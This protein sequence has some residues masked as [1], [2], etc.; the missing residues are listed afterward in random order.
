MK[1]MIIYTSIHH[2]NTEKIAREIAKI[3]NAELVKT[4]EVKIEDID[5]YDLIGF[6]SGIYFMK[7]HPSLLKII[8]EMPL[9][10]K[11]AFIFSTRGGFPVWLCHRA[12]KRRLR[13]KGFRIVGEFSCRGFDTYGILKHVGGINKG[14]P[15]ENDLVRAREFA[16]SLI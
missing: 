11:R 4:D 10:D 14:K 6:G 9:T 16:R 1:S 8:E 2:G 12:I 3:M 15:D 7:H 5:S 13:K